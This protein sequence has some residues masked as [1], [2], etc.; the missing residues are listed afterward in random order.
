MWNPATL[1][2][3]P[4]SEMSFAV[5]LIFPK[6]ELSSSVNAGAFG[7]GQPPI[8][9]AGSTVSEAGISAV[10]YA[11][12]VEKIE[13]SAWSYGLGVFGIGGFRVN[14]PASDSN[15][16]LMPQPPVGL[17]LGSLSSDV[18]ILQ[19]A[20]TIS[21]A[22]SECFSIGFSPTISIAQVGVDPVLF[23]M[24]DD[25]N[26]DHIPSYPEGRGN[27]SFWGGGFQFGI[28]FI[29][30]GGWHYGAA[31]KSPQW[32]EDIRFFT[33][34]E[35][36][37]SHTVSVPFEYPLVASAG[38]AYSG[39]ENWVFAGDIRLF[40]FGN[41]AGFQETGFA[42]DGSLRGLGWDSV[43]AVSCG[44]QFQASE[45]LYLRT[46]YSYNQNPISDSD[47]GFNVASPGILQHFFYCGASVAISPWTFLSIA[48]IHGFENDIS[49]SIQS[50]LG[51]VPGTTVTSSASLDA[52]TA[53][54]AVKY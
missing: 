20:P 41:A 24:P 25:A 15:P 49:G 7:P 54:L 10:P 3:L 35:L 9:L 29:G 38:A 50:P 31:V 26:G 43:V 32:F 37:H 52:I 40:D 21:Y 23:A 44:T 2:G 33:D 47:T 1:S 36:G 27:R 14:Y 46:G 18:E 11:A 42:P 4:T 53:G 5:G 48:Y 28:Y 8:N 39:L 12:I 17:G 6:S 16:I 22:L 51:P 30:D 13:N 34:D 19:I 45:R